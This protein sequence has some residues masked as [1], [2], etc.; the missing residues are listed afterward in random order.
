MLVLH[1]VRLVKFSSIFM[2][3]THCNAKRD[4]YVD[5]KGYLILGTNVLFMIG[6][7]LYFL[8]QI[9]LIIYV[10]QENVCV[11]LACMVVLY[12]YNLSL[13]LAFC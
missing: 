12:C 7:A 2:L 11:I 1:Y 6:T 13:R 4:I 9:Y 8:Q 5:K 3:K 10:R